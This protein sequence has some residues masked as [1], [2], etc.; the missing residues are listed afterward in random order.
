MYRLFL[1]AV[2][3]F[4]SIS[5]MKDESLKRP[6]SGF[7]PVDIGDGWILSSPGHENMDSLKLDEAFR[8]FYKEDQFLLG[9][10]MTIIRNGKIVAEAYSRELN[11]IHQI[12]NIKSATKSFTGIL[13]CIALQN[14]ILDSV[15]QRFSD[16]YPE[17][18]ENHQDKTDIT[19]DQALTMR[20]GLVRDNKDD[21]YDFFMTKNTVE[22]ALSSQMRYPQGTTFYYTDV[23]PQLVSFAIQKKYG[24]PLSEF[25]KEYLFDPLNIK[26]WYWQAG[27]DGVTYGAS[28]LNL[29]PRDMAKFGI[30]LL[31]NGKWG[32][33]QIIDSTFLSEAI[34]AH[35]N[36]QGFSYGYY[37]WLNP[38]DKV[39]WA[40]GHGG[41]T[42]LVAP[43]QN[44]VV[45]VTAWPY[46]KDD[47]RWKDNFEFYLY[48][49]VLESCK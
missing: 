29:K 7:A 39:Y 9:R 15:K 22:F 13:A 47:L 8:Y 48:K 18:F 24:K 31:Q 34:R 35:V 23:N 46:V 33:K 30:L 41:Q 42:I 12:Q 43:Y 27:R 3:A 4:T 36:L 40:A 11:D 1:F 49:K 5:C 32:D 44:L 20:T 25:A 17:Y 37:I 21:G 2:I 14:G 16:I 28:N 19:I 10:S 45:V 6:Y 38:S 26:E